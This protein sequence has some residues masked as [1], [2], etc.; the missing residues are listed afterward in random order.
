[1]STISNRGDARSRFFETD[2]TQTNIEGGN[3]IG[4]P[5]NNII[6]RQTNKETWS[7]K[8]TINI[9]Q[10]RTS[11]NSV[12]YP[13]SALNSKESSPLVHEANAVDEFNSINFTSRKTITNSNSNQSGSSSPNERER[14]SNGHI[15]DSIDETIIENNDL[16][17]IF[18][19]SYNIDVKNIDNFLADKASKSA[20][21]IPKPPRLSLEAE[22]HNICEIQ[23]LDDN[24]TNGKTQQLNSAMH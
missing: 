3:I 20:N 10:S 12:N 6:T 18:I 4:V 11:T 9:P 14:I 24:I 1:M 2:Y 17:T 13:N 8:I 21:S 5:S 19:R 7:H 15:T 23:K 16:K 22:K